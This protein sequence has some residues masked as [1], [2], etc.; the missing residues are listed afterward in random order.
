MT[1]KTFRETYHGGIKRWPDMGALYAEDLDAADAAPIGSM[2]ITRY[3]RTEDG[4][5]WTLEG[6]EERA[7]VTALHYL[8]AFDPGWSVWAR[9]ERNY[10]RYTRFGKLP[11]KNVSISPDGLAKAVRVMTFKA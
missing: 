8:N 10:T 3:T 4:G 11:Y 9:S 6:T 5:R 7:D 1:Y 2:T